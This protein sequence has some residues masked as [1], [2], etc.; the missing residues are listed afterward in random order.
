MNCSNWVTEGDIF[1]KTGKRLNFVG[2]LLLS[3][4]FMIIQ[5]EEKEKGGRKG[6]KSGRGGGM[7][8]ED[9]KRKREWRRKQIRKSKWHALKSGYVSSTM[10]DT[11]I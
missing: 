10:I 8:E 5:K 7:K 6:R 3:K 1:G 4:G 11:F 9:N 2:L